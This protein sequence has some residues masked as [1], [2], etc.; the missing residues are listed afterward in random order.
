MRGK[1]DYSKYQPVRLEP[2]ITYCPKCG[3]PLKFAYRSD[4]HVAFLNHCQEIL[5]EARRCPNPE[6]AGADNRYVPEALHIGMLRKYEYGLDVIALIGEHRLK[7]HDTFA[8]IGQTLRETYG[9]PISDREVQALF[10]LYLALVSTNI[11]EDPDRL[12]KLRAQGKIILGLD[13]AQPEADG[14]S[15]W[16]FRDTL[17][18]EVLKGLSSASMDAE[19]LAIHLREIKDLGIPVTGVTS[20][21]QNIIIQAV[22]KVFPGVAHQLCQIHFLKD[23]AKEVTALDKGLKK[24]IKDHLRGLN[25]FEKAAAENPPKAL[26]E[27][28]IKAPKSVTLSGEPA[29]S[30]PP[31]G[32][33]RTQV[34]LKAPRT[35]QE[36]TLIRDVCEILRAVLKQHGRYPLE[37][38][39]LETRDMLRQVLRALDEGLKKRG[40][41]FSFFG[42]CASTSK[43]H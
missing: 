31:R 14:E 9:V 30:S 27:G 7:K 37:S 22:E 40:P 23:F 36:R 34:R 32:R 12:A 39:G 17:S 18:E 6:C 35:G 15:L 42:N 13:A 21:A 38:P 29:P 25:S 16:I 1:R 3:R 20:D 4:R 19:N 2:E 28:K 43:L 10:D 11:A 5:Y 8:E 26:Q 33:P 24:E 41:D